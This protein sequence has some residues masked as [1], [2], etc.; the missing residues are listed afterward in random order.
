V[1]KADS[2]PP[3]AT[4]HDV[5]LAIWDLASPVT[6][7]SRSKIKVGAR[8]S[9]G[10]SLAGEVIHIQN[11]EGLNVADATVGTDLWPG[12]SALH[13]TEIGIPA[14]TTVGTHMWRAVLE[15]VNAEPVHTRTEFPF[16]YI[17][18]AAPE[19][20]VTLRV[21]GKDDN[22]PLAG[23]EVRL[24]VFRCSTDDAGVARLEVP[25]GSYHFAVWKLGYEAHAKTVEV[26]S[27]VNISVELIAAPEPDQEYW[28]G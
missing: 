10:C 15:P 23:V 3:D 13:W 7:G 25:G 14:P 27:D 9:H 4:P 26:S 20:S 12:T 6:P 1:P 18:V 28:M 19:H 21:I 11:D 22:A 2:Q 24:G 16:R 17:A 8:C 5:S